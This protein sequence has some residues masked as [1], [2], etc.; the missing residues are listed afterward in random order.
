MLKVIAGPEVGEEIRCTGPETVLGK[1]ARSPVRLSSAGVSYEHALIS[2]GQGAFFVENLSAH[3]TYVNEERITGKVKLRTKDRVRL[4]ADTLVRVERVA[5]D[6]SARGG[7]GGGRTKLLLAV[8]VLMLV[9]LVVV[10]AVNPLGAET[11]S[12]NAIAYPKLLEWVDAEVDRKALPAEVG[13][14]MRSGWRLDQAGDSAGAKKEWVR[15]RVL[16]GEVAARG[17]LPSPGPND[18]RALAAL[19]EGKR[20]LDEEGMQAGLVEFVAAKARE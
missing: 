9:G 10:V 13:M 17:G 7:T 19:D 3:G 5:V 15:L 11:S 1:S 14:L 6:G 2:R 8:V 4:S 12:N 18:E 16:L 20:T